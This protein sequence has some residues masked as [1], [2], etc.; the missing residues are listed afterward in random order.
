MA[1]TI[2][3]YDLYG[4][5]ASP[6]WSN[7]FNFE[8]IPQRSKPYQWEIQMHRHDAFV[9][10]LYLS[11]GFAEVTVNNARIRAEAPCFIV[12]PAGAAHGFSFSPQVDGP[13]V[14]ATQKVLESMASLLMPA[15]LAVIRTPRVIPL[16][17]DSRHVDSL[18]PLFLALERESRIHASGQTAAGMSLLI[19]LLVQ[20]ARVAGAPNVGTRAEPAVGSRKNGQIERFKALLDQ[21]YRQHWPVQ[22]YAD[23]M[24]MT[25]GQLSRI[26]REVLGMSSLDVINARLLHEAQRELV[27]TAS[28]VKLLAS[29]LG[30]EDDAY[31]SRFF[32]RHTD[33]SP[34]EFRAQALAQMAG[35]PSP[36]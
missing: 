5:Q 14:T 27:Y 25:A 23:A 15:L 17:A 9:Q 36:N 10:L 8:W 32:K 31:F 28:S 12:I 4:D 1:R 7:S 29:E 24:G 33:M 16:P 34:R 35:V 18:M 19:A 3:N 21:H 26:C 22:H 30:F 11:A 20:V 6:A 2:P 13:V